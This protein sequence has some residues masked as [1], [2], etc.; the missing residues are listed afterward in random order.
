MLPRLLHLWSRG[1]I[2]QANGFIVVATMSGRRLRQPAESGARAG[3]VIDVRVLPALAIV[4]YLKHPISTIISLQCCPSRR[5]TP[6]D[7]RDIWVPK[8]EI[9]SAQEWRCSY[10]VLGAERCNVGEGDSCCSLGCCET[11]RW[12]AKDMFWASLTN[13]RSRLV[14]VAF[15][16]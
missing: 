15:V 13:D 9:V 14:T 16:S 5:T 1:Q 4:H 12:S 6:I 7:F 10:G 2:E 8:I 3:S 11:R